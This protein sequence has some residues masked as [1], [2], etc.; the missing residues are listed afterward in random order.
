MVLML[1]CPNAREGL[2][3]FGV[4]LPGAGEI[5]FDGLFD[6]PLE[7]LAFGLGVFV[8]VGFQKFLADLCARDG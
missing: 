7:G 5:G 4:D 2:E 3:A 8:R 6:G 1:S